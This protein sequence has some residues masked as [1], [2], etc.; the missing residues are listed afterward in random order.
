MKYDLNTRTDT[1]TVY[2]VLT[3]QSLKHQLVSQ[4]FLVLGCELYFWHLAT[5]DADETWWQRLWNR[6]C[7]SAL[8]GRGRLYCAGCERAGVGILSKLSRPMYLLLNDRSDA[9]LDRQQSS[10]ACAGKKSL[11]RMLHGVEED[12]CMSED[13]VV[14][15]ARLVLEEA[16]DMSSIVVGEML[17]GKREAKLTTAV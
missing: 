2:V 16:T 5:T 9:F 1:D 11:R 7:S 13:D 10:V 15:D 3:F 6:T 14:V 17:S 8:D 4:S 12:T